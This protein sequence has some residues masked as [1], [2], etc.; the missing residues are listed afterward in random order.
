[1]KLEFDGIVVESATAD[2]VRGA[3]A[4]RSNRSDYSI[5]LTA[6]DANGIDADWIDGAYHIST[7]E[8]GRFDDADRPF[9]ESETRDL[10]LKYLARDRRWREAATWVAWPEA[11]AAAASGA[12]SRVT[13]QATNAP[14]FLDRVPIVARIV[15]GIAAM[16]VFPMVFHAFTSVFERLS[17]PRWLDSVPARIF[18]GFFVAVVLITA[19]VTV[20]KV[21]EVRA[22]ARWPKTAGRIVRSQPRFQIVQARSEDMPVNER[23]VDIVYE[24]EVGKKTYR[25]SRVTFAEKIGAEEI[26]QLLAKYPKGKAVDV[27]YDPVRPDQA[28]LDRTMD[29]LGRGCLV[30]LAIG[31]VSVIVLMVAVTQG[32]DLIHRGLP[33]AIVPMVAILGLGGLMVLSVGWTLVKSSIEAR[34]W[35]K[36]VGHVTLSGVHD[37]ETI[38]TSSSSSSSQ[39]TYRREGHM[40]VVEYEYG[41]GGKP[42]KSRHVK[43]DTEVGGSMSFAKGVAA[44][45]PVGK[46]V[47]VRY[48][49]KNP[50]RAYLELST[51]MGW[52]TLALAV[53]LLIATA[54]AAGLMTD[55]P[56]LKMG[57]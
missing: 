14:S 50:E 39:R 27:F 56:P 21:R 45:Y 49:P 38:E 48:D 12:A 2:D 22:A 28:V 26:P 23:T 5:S 55:G 43:L 8:K 53:A 19:V 37:Y 4:G 25:A 17:L 54:W 18:L 34:R 32:P 1:M 10:F 36:A 57:R 11:G 15:I 44:K 41:V 20:M 16:F 31:A 46:I 6:D 52:F 40:P 9:G 29:G 13:A 24:Y 33:N 30:M 47:T 51:W 35:P 42:Y 3:F 7:S